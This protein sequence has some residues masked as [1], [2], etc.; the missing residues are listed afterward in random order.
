MEQSAARIT[1]A[2][3]WLLLV[4]AAVQLTH[5]LDFMIVMPLQP[6]IKGELQMEPWHFGAMVSAY[7]FSASLA[8]LLAA[9]LIDRFDRK[10]SLLVLYAGFTAG[11]LLCALASNYG[12]LVLGR[13]V[14]GAFGG[15]V[16]ALASTIVGDVRI[17]RDGR[18]GRAMG[19]LMS[20]FSVASIAGIR[21][22][23]LPRPTYLG[24]HAPFAALARSA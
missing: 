22:G 12:L 4:L 9:S 23:P 20:A 21:P 17:C 15:V 13:V 7:G 5:I 3:G 1:R 11:T 14:A 18:R 19:V 2:E 24:W 6:H 8:G 16:A 10:R